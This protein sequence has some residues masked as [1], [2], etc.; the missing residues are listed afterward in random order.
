MK[1][2]EGAEWAKF[3]NRKQKAEANSGPYVV[4]HISAFLEHPSLSRDFKRLI[5]C[6]Q[7]ST[8]AFQDNWNRILSIMSFI[9]GKKFSVSPVRRALIMTAS[10]GPRLTYPSSSPEPSSPEEGYST[11]PLPELRATLDLEY[12]PLKTAKK[13]YS[14]SRPIGEGGF[15]RVFMSKSSTLKRRVAIKKI[16]IESR[17]E[18]KI[19]A[20]IACYKHL[21]HPNIVKVYHT[22]QTDAEY[23]IV[24]ECLEGGNLFVARRLYKFQEAHMGFF[25]REI[26]KGLAYIHERLYIHRDVTTNNIML[27]S[28]DGQIRLIDFGLSLKLTSEQPITARM[29]GTPVAMPPEVIRSNSA[30]LAVDI[31]S[32]GMLLLEL[33]CGRGSLPDGYTCMFSACFGQAAIPIPDSS[34]GYS[35][36]FRDFLSKALDPNPEKRSTAQQLLHHQ[37]LQ[38]PDIPKDMKSIFM[39]IFVQNALVIYGF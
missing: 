2:S 31:W 13:L 38:S 39:Q 19:L 9:S 34:S 26:L 25:A 14:G 29:S 18:K 10:G 36:A 8:V 24:M 17:S 11:M 22:K 12:I 7:F 1:P 5:T 35:V 6:S 32:L 4:P 33:V 15:S 3:L 21:N 28:L 16:R 23:W 30:S 27:S 37:W 20:E